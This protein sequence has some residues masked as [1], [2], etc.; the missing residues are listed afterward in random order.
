ME[1]NQENEV[2]IEPQREQEQNQDL[3]RVSIHTW[4]SNSAEEEIQG[5][6]NV[7][8]ND[9]DDENMTIMEFRQRLMAERQR[10]EEE[11][12]NLIRQNEGLREENLRLREQR[13]ESRMQSRLR[14]SG[15]TSTQSRFNKRNVRRRDRMENIE[16]NIQE[17]HNLQDQRERISIAHDLGTHRYVH[18]RELLHRTKN[19]FE[20]EGEDPRMG[21]IDIAWKRTVEIKR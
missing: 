7:G 6:E 16:E 15:E 2:S 8:R 9:G 20:R 14:S 3:D 4:R 1:Q 13:S 10:Q 5:I 17:G 12:E 18:S 19:N 11:R 21:Q